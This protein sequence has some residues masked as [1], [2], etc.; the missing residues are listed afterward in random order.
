MDHDFEAIVNRLRTAYCRSG[1]NQQQELLDQ[2]WLLV[3]KVEDPEPERDRRST[4]CTIRC[5]CCREEL[6][7]TL[8]C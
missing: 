8:G 7:V 1:S 2:L 5:P 4:P 6:T 3:P